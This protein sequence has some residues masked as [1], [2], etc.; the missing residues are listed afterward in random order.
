[1]KRWTDEEMDQLIG[2]LLWA[3]VL[4]AAVVVLIGGGLYLHRHAGDEIAWTTF[5]EEPTELRRPGRI[6]VSAFDGRGPAVI[7]L[8]LLL[9]IATPVARVALAGYIFLRERDWLYTLVSL[10]VLAT[11][12]FSLAA[13]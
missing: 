8:G 12:L 4:I 5:R 7:E 9:L 2:H 11:L 3:G 13:P 6:V 10:L 1:V